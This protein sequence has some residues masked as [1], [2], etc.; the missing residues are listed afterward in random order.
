MIRLN[1][2]IKGT[3]IIAAILIMLI[4]SVM[5]LAAASLL[6]TDTASSLNYMN[7]QEAFFIAE[8]GLEYYLE[9]LQGQTTSWTTPPTKPTNETLGKG[10]FTITTANEQ[11]NSI[12]VTSTANLTGIGGETITRVV[13]VQVRR[14]SAPEA[15]SYVLYVG[16]TIVTTGATNLTV[17]GDQQEGGSNFP[18]VNF[19]YYQDLAPPSQKISGNH[20]FTSGGSPY[21]GIWYVNGN[22]TINS[23]VT[24]NGT[25]VAT[26][27]IRGREEQDITV[28]PTLAYPALVSN[29]YIDF[30]DSDDVTINGLVYAGADGS[31]TFSARGTEDFSLTGTI[32]VAQWITFQDSE[33]A[34]ITYDSSIVT[35]PPP[36]FSG[37]GSQ[38]VGISN[39]DEV[40]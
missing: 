13:T 37:S 10:T 28:N 21:S 36:G 38:T 17:T 1:T 15:F 29:N 31:G 24:I 34:T 32:I 7:S 4:A 8:G 6:G 40:Y 26:G 22:V 27:W 19:S 25:V 12:D 18:T 5:G 30:R 35:N 23:D 33:D 11:A 16:N 9:Q 2:D 3:A 14:Q 20:I 39:W